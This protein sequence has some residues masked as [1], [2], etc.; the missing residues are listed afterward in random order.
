MVFHKDCLFVHRARQ[1]YYP[2]NNLGHQ[3]IPKRA[4]HMRKKGIA[5]KQERLKL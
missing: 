1:K 4:I 5:L 2:Q 3:N